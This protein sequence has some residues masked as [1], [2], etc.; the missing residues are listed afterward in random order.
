MSAGERRKFSGDHLS[1]FSDSSRK[2]ASP[3]VSTS[4]RMPSTVART[5]ASLAATSLASR[6]RF[7]CLAIVLVLGSRRRPERPLRARDDIDYG[8]TVGSIL[9]SLY[10][11]AGGSHFWQLMPGSLGAFT[12]SAGSGW[13]VLPGVGA[14]SRADLRLS[15]GRNSG[16]KTSVTKEL[17]TFPSGKALHP[18]SN[19]S[20]LQSVTLSAGTQG[21]GYWMFIAFRSRFFV[22]ISII[23]LNA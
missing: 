17:D 15:S 14:P 8:F 21:R 16:L 20:P 19:V 3:R 22:R 6:P 13:I 4:V 11:S 2:A 12:T 10:K 7:R 9:V 23:S 5:L 1:N 18:S